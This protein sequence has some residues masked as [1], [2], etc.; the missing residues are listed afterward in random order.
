MFAIGCKESPA[1]VAGRM[2]NNRGEYLLTDQTSFDP[3]LE[4]KEEWKPL[5]KK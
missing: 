4:F 2:V 3:N 1:P 5:E